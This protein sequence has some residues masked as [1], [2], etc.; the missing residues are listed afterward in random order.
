MAWYAFNSS[1]I[2]YVHAWYLTPNALAKVIGESWNLELFYESWSFSSFICFEFSVA[3][4][5]FNKYTLLFKNQQKPELRSN[6]DLLLFC[7]LVSVLSRWH[8]SR[9]HS[10]FNISNLSIKRKS[11]VLKLVSRIFCN[12]CRHPW[13]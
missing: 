4:I 5:S 2:I 11:N 1:K 13:L 12:S 8:V 6:G 3:S 7:S 10:Q 9:I